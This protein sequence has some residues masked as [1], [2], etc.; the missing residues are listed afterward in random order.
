M[1]ALV[2]TEYK[3]F[4]Y[5]D[6]K[7]PIPQKDEVL[8]K[9]HACGICGS[10][11]H[12]YDGSS[13]RRIPPIIMGHEAS[14]EIVSTG[15]EVRDWKA[16]ERVTF[17]STIYCGKCEFC[18][19]GQINLCDNR[20]V[21]GVSCADYKQDGAFAEYL[22]VPQ[23]ILYR[24][25]DRVS[26]E[27]ACLV[28]PLSIAFHAVDI[29]PIHI[30]DTVAVVGCGMIGLL[31]IQTLRLAGCGD[32]IALDIDPKKLELAKKIGAD[33]AIDSGK[34]NV[35]QR[36]REIAGGGVNTAFDVVG[37]NSS[38]ATA[39][40]VLKKG[41]WLTLIGNLSPKV[42]FPLQS[43]VTRQISVQGS[44]A[45]SGEYGACLDMIA[46]KA[47]DIDFLISQIAPLEE[48]QVWFDRLYAGREELLKVILKP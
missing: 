18:R 3:K 46:R 31:V 36:L 33:F 47:V 28:E 27:Q 9:V 5:M 16:G 42:D 14:G 23:H 19:K 30:N 38:I 25:P 12:G 45:S 32:I 22:A 44:C 7:D 4:T 24:L 26:Y 17:D 1:K 15:S 48:G 34:E 35:E 43:S 21:L 39:A 10:D 2:L 11:V 41:G 29:T 40:A 6:M 20:R 13:G 8:I 37:I